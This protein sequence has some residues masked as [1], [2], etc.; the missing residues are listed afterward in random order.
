VTDIILTKDEQRHVNDAC[1]AAVSYLELTYVPIESLRES[2][3]H[4]CVYAAMM[5]NAPDAQ[6]VTL[7]QA[8]SL[9]MYI[10]NT[11]AH[12]RPRMTKERMRTMQI[13]LAKTRYKLDGTHTGYENDTLVT[14]D[15]S[16]VLGCS[17]GVTNALKEFRSGS[18][19]EH[20]VYTREPLLYVTMR[21]LYR[22]YDS[23]YPMSVYVPDLVTVV[24]KWDDLHVKAMKASMKSTATGFATTSTT[25]STA[26]VYDKIVQDMQ[27]Y[28]GPNNEVQPDVMRGKKMNACAEC[29]NPTPAPFKMCQRCRARRAQQQEG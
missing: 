6:T 13:A 2:F 1:E 17:P 15:H 23:Q 26:S 21:S 29:G 18:Y 16:S 19:G 27:F 11:H 4:R 7:A 9:R 8:L 20:S 14:M 5:T 10:M 3:I 24:R 25:A 22:S 28:N 12:N